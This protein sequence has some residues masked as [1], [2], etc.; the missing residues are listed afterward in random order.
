MMKKLLIL[1]AVVMLTGST[2]GCRCCN[3][4]FRGA[5][6]PCPPQG[7]YGEPCAPSYNPCDPCT[8]PGAPQGIAPGPAPYSSVPAQQ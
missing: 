8:T 5:Y 3:W 1:T 6:N 4:M 2:V 7:A